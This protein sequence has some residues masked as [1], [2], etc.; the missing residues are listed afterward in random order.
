MPRATQKKQS[1]KTTKKVQIK[2][3]RVSLKKAGATKGGVAKT[4]GPAGTLWWNPIPIQPLKEKTPLSRPR[5]GAY[6]KGGRGPQG[7]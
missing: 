7:G 1:K 3:L 4:H 6:R 2:D 5:V